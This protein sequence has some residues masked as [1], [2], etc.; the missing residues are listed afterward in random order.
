MSLCTNELGVDKVRDHCHVTGK[1]RGAAH[2]ACNS[3]C[4]GYANLVGNYQ[5]L[6]II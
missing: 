5:L 3:A 1:Y 2:N 4:V 6:Y